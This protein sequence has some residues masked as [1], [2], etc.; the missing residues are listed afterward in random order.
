MPS[1]AYPTGLQKILDDTIALASDNI[2]CG[3]IDLNDEGIAISSSTNATPI[4]VTVGSTTGIA[5]GDYVMIARHTVNT[6]A[7][8]VWKVAGVTGTTINLTHADDT[9]STGNGVGGAT[10][11]VVRLDKV[12]VSDLAAN[13]LVARSANLGTKTFTSGTF[14]AADTTFTAV[15]G[16]P[17][18]AWIVFEDTGADASSSLILIS[19]RKADNSAFDVTPNGGDINLQFAAAGVAVFRTPTGTSS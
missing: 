19:D 14:D 18:E 4:V 9:N 16:D 12:F 3:L 5:N 11:F 17:C 10:G 15:T 2:K 7:V 6:N 8:G 13:A 1:A